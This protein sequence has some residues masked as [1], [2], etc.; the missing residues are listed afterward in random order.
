MI[1]FLDYLKESKD[2][3]YIYNLNL[4]IYGL[5]NQDRYI[6]IVRDEWNCPEEYNDIYF[7]DPTYWVLSLKDWFNIIQ[8]GSLL[9]W[10]CSCLNKKYIVK[11]YVKLL[12]T[13]NP[14]QLR[15]EIDKNLQSINNDCDI[16]DK[17][18][19][20]KDIKFANQIIENHK[21]I[22]FKEVNSDYNKLMSSS[23]E[24]ILREPYTR[25]KTLT[26]G[27]LKQDIIRRA[28]AKNV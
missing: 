14:L 12:M 22:N 25:L 26:D 23:F 5:R 6:V 11:E 18:E 3:L 13:T 17:W 9:G 27:V 24:D 1:S 19:I 7:E 21:I 10:E 8:S 2:C 4:S 28:N 20:I 16:M 15:K